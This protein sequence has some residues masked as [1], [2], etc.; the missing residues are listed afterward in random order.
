[1]NEEQSFSFNPATNRR[2]L[3]A[4]IAV[5]VLSLIFNYF[6]EWENNMLQHLDGSPASAGE[7][8]KANYR[9]VL[10]SMPIIGIII[11]SLL[12]FVP[13]KKLTYKDK[14]PRFVLISVLLI[15]SLT[16]LSFG[17]S[18]IRYILKI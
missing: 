15:S 17:I 6:T 12:T 2:I 3:F 7:I 18:F 10:F 1:M 13:Y 4:I 8:K 14:W 16:F 9:A 5:S 11:G